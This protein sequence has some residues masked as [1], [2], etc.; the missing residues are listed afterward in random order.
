[1]ATVNQ[2]DNVNGVGGQT[3]NQGG[4]TN[5][6]DRPS[7][8]HSEGVIGIGDTTS[9]HG[10]HKSNPLAPNENDCFVGK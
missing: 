6:I 5:G 9:N 10:C 8:N 4:A 2:R 3:V 1:M 7:V